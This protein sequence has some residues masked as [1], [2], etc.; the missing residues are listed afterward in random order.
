MITQIKNKLTKKSLVLFSTLT[1]VF[2][3]PVKVGRNLATALTTLL[4]LSIFVDNLIS[5]TVSTSTTGSV[6]VKN[7]STL[8]IDDFDDGV[9]PNNLGAPGGSFTGSG[10]T[11]NEIIVSTVAVGGSGCS[12]QIN[13]NVS[14]N[15]SYSG[16]W[17]RFHHTNPRD[18]SDYK[19]LSFYVKGGVGGEFF[20]IELSTGAGGWKSR[21]Y[22][23]DYLDGG[24]TTQWKKVTIPFDNFCNVTDWTKIYEMTIVFEKS[25]ATTNNSSTSGS[26]YI[27]NLIIGSE[28][29]GTVRF[30]YYGD[31]LGVNSTGGEMGDVF[32]TASIVR[33]FSSSQYHSSPNCLQMDYDVRVVDSYAGVFNI[34]GGTT[35]GWGKVAQDFSPYSQITFWIKAKPGVNNP[36][37]M[38]VE[39]KRTGYTINTYIIIDISTSW[40]KMTIPFYH[41]SGLSTAGY[42]IDEVVFIIKYWDTPYGHEVGTVYIDDVQFEKSGYS[43]DTTLPIVPTNLKVM[44]TAVGRTV[45]DSDNFTWINWLTCTANSGLQDST[46]ES[47]RFEY[48]P[49]AGSWITIGT[50]YDISDNTYS[51]YWDTAEL[52]E[53]P[54]T[55][56]LRAIARDSSG[57]ESAMAPKTNLTV[58]HYPDIT[59][60]TDDQLLDLIQKQIFWYYWVESNPDK[61]IVQDRTKNF[62]SD[63][64]GYTSVAATGLGLV[65]ICIAHSR[66]WI[67]FTDAYNRIYTI[68]SAYFNAPESSEAGSPMLV[69]YKG[70]YYHY[71][72]F[73]GAR[74]SGSELSTIDSSIFLSGALFAGKYFKNYGYNAPWDFADQMYRR[75]DWNWMLNGNNLLD[76]GWTPEGGFNQTE[77]GNYSECILA[78]MLGVGS[79][80]SVKK[81]PN[82]N[83]WNS[84]TRAPATYNDISYIFEKSLFTH[85][86]PQLFIDLQGKKDAY[87]C[88]AT[89][90]FE[91]TIHQHKYAYDNRTLYSTYNENSWGLGGSD[92]SGG[93]HAY[94]I[95]DHDG[96]VAISN[97]LTAIT[98]R[99]TQVISAMRY[100]YGNYK[101][102]IWGKYTFCDSY[103][104]V[105]GMWRTPDVVGVQQGAALI[106]IENK[107]SNL[108]KNT[109]SNLTY[110]QNAFTI[111][112]FN[113]DITSPGKIT[114]LSAQTTN[115][116]VKL[117]WTATGD[118][119]TTGNISNGMY[120]IKFSTVATDTWDTAPNK[121]L[122]YGII[123][124]TNVV[125]GS[126]QSRIISNLPG[127]KMYYFWLKL[128]DDSF[129]WSPSSDK[130]TFY[131]ADTTL[132]SAITNLSALTGAL[133]G[134]I[135]LSWSTP[136]D[137][138][139][140]NTLLL[141]SQYKIQ[142]SVSA[143]E[144]WSIT[145]AQIVISTS[146][147]NPNVVVGRV[148]TGLTEGTVYYFRIWT[149]D[150]AENWSGI[151]NSAS[152]PAKVVDAV[153][154]AQINTLSAVT[155]IL[156]G[157]INLTWQTPGDDGS[158]GVLP[159]GSQYKIQYSVSASEPWSI[160][161]AQIAISTSGVNPNVVVGRVVTGLT[162]GTVYYF[163]IWTCDE[164]GN[165]SGISNSASATVRLW[166]LWDDCNSHYWCPEG[167]GV[168]APTLTWVS[169]QGRQCL[170]AHW[171]A[172]ADGG[173]MR[174][175]WTFSNENWESPVTGFKADVYI[176]SSANTIDVGIQPRPRT[177]DPAIETLWNS[178]LALNQWLPI[179]YTFTSALDYSTVAAIT[180]SIQQLG[181][182]ASDVYFDNIRLVSSSVE[183]WDNMDDP[184]RIW[185]YGGDFVNWNAS[186]LGR[187]EPITHNYTCP[188]SSAASVFLQWSGAISGYAKVTSGDN[189]NANW[190][191][192]KS[193]KIWARCSSTTNNIK[194]G[195]WDGA[196]YSTT[197]VKKAPTAN[198]WTE[199]T[200][201][202]PTGIAWESVD[203]IEFI[204]ETNSGASSGTIYVDD[205]RFSGEVI[206]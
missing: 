168:T 17:T 181:G 6:Y 35:T 110:I 133:G 27:D 63:T 138:G 3:Q 157:E 52:S 161:N 42:K 2:F 14:A 73:G 91:A 59:T 65:N 49:S 101:N 44:D 122:D 143:S 188:V 141:G 51:A 192:Y 74:V 41:F 88:Y 31:K 4:V 201:N 81:L 137:D 92:G 104:T 183:D 48:R 145:N 46:L 202:L 83:G 160:T 75:V 53:S 96:T 106:A 45:A 11:A 174:T 187:K 89:N 40:K 120:E 112:G 132:P 171:N 149:C 108:V 37:K 10:G 173:Y 23:N 129:N 182:V 195:F 115:G 193:V 162:E 199:L 15:E 170:K 8:I 33:S 62:T 60:M 196:I 79:P 95:G 118:D 56:E 190:S 87:D 43:G 28:F 80:E 200:Y 72:N 100:L 24:V 84:L 155:G 175:D 136:G 205:I 126:N 30:D 19:Y 156:G 102:N 64:Y 139:L 121:Y 12:L 167:W 22:I 172:G 67:N 93:Y 97:L 166:T 86:Y 58:K 169:F 124:S 36:E 184:S 98:E 146:G 1:G 179:S 125:A 20:K 127:N 16:Y 176:D 131:V 204:V 18:L 105:G 47:I 61:G 185:T 82:A 197:S 38:Q 13:Y 76:W 119:G 5:L 159:L 189:L 178:N 180:F 116:N 203:S 130:L 50:D 148:V 9:S 198:I 54:Q 163:R 7:P 165:W 99:P 109:F 194:I 153:P 21:I 34:V 123:W 152:A 186:H 147:V 206:P 26:I 57:N 69:R 85:Q 25:A 150:E 55:Y 177:F 142:Y 68:L 151:S 77:M 29:Q 103:N 134:E 158:L 154:P 90:T 117:I 107:R 111:L 164:A 66:G 71:T 94:G 78:Y 144:P 39:L 70:F 32:D 135:N 140:S 128:C 191:G 114:D 113:N